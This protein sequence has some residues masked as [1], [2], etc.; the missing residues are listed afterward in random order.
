MTTGAIGWNGL[1]R[2]F[3]SGFGELLEKQ[4]SENKSLGAFRLSRILG[5]R[6]KRESASWSGGQLATINQ[7]DFF[8]IRNRLRKSPF[9]FSSVS[10]MKAVPIIGYQ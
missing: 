2:L 5:V 7:K 4:Q 10:K 6:V 3:L 1:S 8:Q 9:D